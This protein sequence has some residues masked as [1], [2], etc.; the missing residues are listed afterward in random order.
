MENM[1]KEMKITTIREKFIDEWVVVQ[2]TKSDKYN[3]PLRGIVLFHGT[4]EEDVYDRGFEYRDRNPDSDLYIF[5][6]GD[7]VPKGMGVLLGASR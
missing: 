2:I 1:E 3:N 4:D 7:L 6:T 5:Y